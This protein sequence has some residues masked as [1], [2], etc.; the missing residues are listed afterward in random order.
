[1]NIKAREKLLNVLIFIG[2]LGLLFVVGYPQYRESLPSKVRIGVD[3][4][5]GSVPFYVAHEDTTRGYFILEKVEPEFIE[6]TGDALQ[7]LKDGL[8]DVA[9]VPW[10]SLLVS[11]SMDGDT[12]RAFGALEVKSGMNMDALILPP[13]S[14][15]TRLPD[16]KG[17]RLGYMQSDEYIVNLIVAK[18]DEQ[19]ITGIQK[20]PLRGDEVPTAFSNDIVDALYLIDP[21]RGYM[22]FN[23]NVV[24]MEG[25]ISSYIMPS[26]PYYAIVMRENYVKEENKVGAIRVKEAIEASLSYVNRNPDIAKR[27]LLK[28]LG[29]QLQ[30]ILLSTIKTPDFKRLAEVNLKYVEYYQTE[31]VRRGIGTCGFKPSEFL[32][33]RVDFVR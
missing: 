28:H 16:L 26:I 22:I 17:K 9:A 21:F 27:T 5:Y 23:G 30:P 29:W 2:A 13:E 11:P 1:M 7:G 25:L 4:T 15:I 20:V 18:M 24:F 32:F 8:Y 10:Y 14:K 6:I 3:K 33:E 31:L 19:K 12:V